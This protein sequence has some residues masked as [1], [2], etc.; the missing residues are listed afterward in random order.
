MKL[1]GSLLAAPLLLAAAAGAQAQPHIPLSPALMTGCDQATYV[2]TTTS[3][4]FTIAPGIAGQGIY[5]CG[6][7]FTATNTG[8]VTIEN[9]PVS[10]CSTSVSAS[11]SL[12]LS[13]SAPLVDHVPFYTGAMA[14][15]AG[16]NLC[17]LSSV[18]GTV[19]GF[20]YWT[21]F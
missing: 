1:S 13:S 4:A 21:Q 12:F 8:S 15:P 18:S 5:V 20:V 2:N 19:Q 16:N 11:F 17:V 6:W 10:A 9:S 14:V 3:T 7:D